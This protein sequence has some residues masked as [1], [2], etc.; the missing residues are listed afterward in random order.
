MHP[1]PWET[2]LSI[3]SGEQLLT[4]SFKHESQGVCIIFSS[5]CNDV[6]IASTFQ[7]FGHTTIEKIEGLKRTP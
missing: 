1:Q 4:W 5:Q 2:V 3:Y 6:F 7:Y